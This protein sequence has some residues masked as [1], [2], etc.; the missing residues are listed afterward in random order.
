[1]SVV[2][3][4]DGDG[5]VAG[6][7]AHNPLLAA[8][9]L[10]LLLATLCSCS[11]KFTRPAAGPPELR[12]LSIADDSGN[13]DNAARVRTSLTQVLPLL[14]RWGTFREP[15]S[16][17]IL[18]DHA[19]L[20]RAAHQSDLPWLRG[21]TFP[22]EIL[23]QAPSSWP[24]D[25]SDEHSL[26][27]LLA[28]ELTHALLYQL[29]AGPQGTVAPAPPP[30]FVEGMAS[31]TAHQEARRLTQ[32]QL[33]DWLTTH[34]GVDPFTFSDLLLHNEQRALYSA[35]H[36]AFQRL[37]DQF[38]EAKILAILVEERAGAP[39]AV[40]FQHQSHVSEG[41]FLA[42]QLTSVRAPQ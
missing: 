37:L 28:H 30:W 10:C 20:E 16:I 1:V 39:F 34:P 42:R 19:A 2:G 25:L 3:D 36:L 40:A 22:N 35:A 11:P 7:S 29:L 31:V 24:S 26:S 21:W 6:R 4:G 14:E 32:N 17:R 33:R 15:V 27:A 41:G 13:P 38:G 9:V 5:E 18:R 23:L 8:N 12:E